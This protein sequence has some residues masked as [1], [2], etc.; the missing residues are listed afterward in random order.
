MVGV[1][2]PLATVSAMVVLAVVLPL[3]P[4]MVTVEVP[5]VAVL[6]AVSVSVLEVVDDVG[7]N[8]AVTPL[9]N[10]VAVNDTLPVNPFSGV[11]EIVSVALLPCVTES[12]DAER[13]SVKVEP[14]PAGMRMP[15]AE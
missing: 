13:E 10:P 11:T 14:V 4:V 15:I 9:G 6:L 3:V 2:A 7:L 5:A 8:E 1:Q 12:V